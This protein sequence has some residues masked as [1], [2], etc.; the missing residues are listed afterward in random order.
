M[1]KTLYDTGR[2]V[3]PQALVGRVLPEGCHSLYGGSLLTNW[4]AGKD[5]SVDGTA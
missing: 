2:P 1:Y 5:G 4:E 3:L